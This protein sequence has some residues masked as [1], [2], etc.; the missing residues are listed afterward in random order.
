MD[1]PGTKSKSPLML[2]LQ[3]LKKK[4]LKSSL[5]VLDITESQAQEIDFINCMMAL[6][7]G[8][9][10]LFSGHH[11]QSVV[12][13]RNATPLLEIINDG[14]TKFIVHTLANFAEGI[15]LLLQGNAHE[16]AKL[17]KIGSKE[18]Q[19]LNFFIPGM[20][21]L[22]LSFKAAA[23]MAVA[24]T[25]LNIGDMPSV[26]STFGKILQIHEEFLSKLDETKHED[27][28]FFQEIFG[29]QVELSLIFMRLDLEVL[30]FDSLAK[31]IEFTKENFN[32]LGS[33]IEKSSKSITN[34]NPIKKVLEITQL[35]Y[36]IFEIY[37]RIGKSVIMERVPL[38]KCQIKE[39]L[40]AD[41]KIFE[42]HQ[43]ANNAGD[44]G[45]LYL[46]TINQLKR[47]NYS[48]FVIGKV[49]KN[50]FGMKSGLIALCAL[51]VQIV[52]VHLTIK[53]TGNAAITFF[54]GE[55]IVSII[56]GYGYG[57]LKF[58]PLLNLYSD[59]IKRKTVIEKDNTK[60]VT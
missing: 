1:A 50:D 58:I 11:S 4:D 54:L 37:S 45:K 16:A 36:E 25:Y 26:E 8:L 21:K 22:L 9:N 42:A 53:P 34:T 32:K 28:P 20:E 10:L 43:K 23:E 51:I 5:E 18:V 47:L 56:A 46:Y 33:F 2:S 15:S 13:L 27:F 60:L 48:L 12:H 31:R 55:I 41:N 35:L 29:T 24:K 57:A 59:T 14:E 30:D 6:E 38:T 39:L 52:I 17:L 49:Q 44:R 40:I 3:Y 19:R 7:E